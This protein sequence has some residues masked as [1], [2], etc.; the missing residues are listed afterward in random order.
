MEQNSLPFP[1]PEPT[2][3]FW[4]SQLQ[5]LGDPVPVLEQLPHEII[6]TAIVGLCFRRLHRVVLS[7]RP[8]C[9][10]FAGAGISGVGVA[11]FL[12]QEESQT[13][14][15]IVVFDARGIAEGAFSRPHRSVP[16]SG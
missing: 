5:G 12:S 1:S 7:D 15:D 2:L 6:D 9:F 10:F 3:S 8:T 16:I 11:Y 4:L 13:P 14:K